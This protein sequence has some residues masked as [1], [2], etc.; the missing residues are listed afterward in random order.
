MHTYR[1]SISIHT[2]LGNITHIYISIA[3]SLLFSLT[4]VG[5][6]SVVSIA[7]CDVTHHGAKGDNITESTDAFVSAIEACQGP[8]KGAVVVPAGHFLLRPI[9]LLSHTELVIMPSATLIAWPGI[10]WRNGWPNSTTRNCSSSPYGA[11]HPVMVPRL[12]SLLYG[13]AVNNITIR[14]GGKVDGQVW[15]RFVERFLPQIQMII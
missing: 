15:Y 7:D 5:A 6:T 14:G 11:Q 2:Y 1:S 13:D 8:T 3:I 10:G 4:S 12:E 9:K